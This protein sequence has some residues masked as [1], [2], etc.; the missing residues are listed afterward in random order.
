MSGNHKDTTEHNI[1][2][3]TKSLS[4]TRIENTSLFRRPG[5]LV[6][7][8]GVAENTN[9][10]YWFDIREA[11]IERKNNYLEANCFLLLRVVPDKFILCRFDK[12]EKILIS[13]KVSNGKKAWEFHIIDG[14]S[15]IKNRR[16][17]DFIHVQL[18]DKYK[19]I[20]LLQ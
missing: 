8:P 9:G 6:F 3:L 20:E 15:K 14:F 2:V 11:N 19:V 10:H 12:I 4:L 5:L 7:S 18:I 16:T 17:D 13:P 1:E